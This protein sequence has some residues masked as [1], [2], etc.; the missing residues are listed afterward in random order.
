MRE[1]ELI[2]QMA[3]SSLGHAYLNRKDTAAFLAQQDAVYRQVIDAVGMR[4]APK[5]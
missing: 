4:V 2:K 1:P 3:N 5:N